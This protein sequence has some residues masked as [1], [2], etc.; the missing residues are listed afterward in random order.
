MSRMMFGRAVALLILGG[1]SML[2]GPTASGQE[3]KPDL[4]AMIAKPTKH[5]ELLKKDVGTWDA[6]VKMWMAG[7]DAPPEE[8]KGVE[9]TTLL[10]DGLWAVSTFEGEFGGMKFRGQGQLGYDSKKGKYV[11]TW[12]DTMTDHI[13]FM[14]GTYDEAEKTLTMFMDSTDPATGKP[15]KEKHVVKYVDPDTRSFTFSMPGPD[16]KDFKVMEI[17]YKKRKS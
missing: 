5:H 16:G 8:S 15:V 10:G 6:T 4:D 11:G 12:I 17:T 2:P 14:E 1:L 7:P 13:G 9:T 3:E